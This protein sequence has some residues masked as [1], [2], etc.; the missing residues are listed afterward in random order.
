MIHP[1]EKHRL[2]RDQHE[3]MHNRI[4]V[5]SKEADNSI[6]TERENWRR[7]FRVKIRCE[8]EVEGNLPVSI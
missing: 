8:T 3:P 2:S 4:G 1:V 5:L 6:L 7:I